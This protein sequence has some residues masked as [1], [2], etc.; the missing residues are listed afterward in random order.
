MMKL[1][2]KNKLALVLFAL[3]PVIVMPASA[4]VY[5]WVDENGNVI[6][7]DKPP[8]PKAQK[9][10]IK[11]APPADQG[12]R[13]RLKKRQKLLDTLDDDRE[14][15]QA[16]AQKLAEREALQQERCQRVQADLTRMKN[17]GYLYEETDDPFNPSILSDEQRTQEQRRYQDYLDKNC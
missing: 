3:L 15:E 13:D 16:N 2:G 12:Y 17:A 14:N 11:Q 10:Q 9:L 1:T 4:G 8:G 7:G 6:Y 5:K